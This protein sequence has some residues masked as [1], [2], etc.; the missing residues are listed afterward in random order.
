MLNNA[1]IYG[2]GPI[3]LIPLVSQNAGIRL[4]PADIPLLSVCSKTMISFNLS[5]SSDSS[6]ENSALVSKKTSV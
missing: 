2:L 6:F 1:F 3:C 4:S 5:A